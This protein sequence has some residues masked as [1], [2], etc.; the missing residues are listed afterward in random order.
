M[1]WAGLNAS[2]VTFWLCVMGCK[3]GRED[4]GDWDV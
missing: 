2:K 1:K 4:E 3:D